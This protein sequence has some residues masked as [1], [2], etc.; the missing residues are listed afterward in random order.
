MTTT[1]LFALESDSDILREYKSG[2]TERAVTFF[3]R[4]Y[5][6]FVYSIALRY[7]KNNED[8]QDIAQDVFVKA[9]SSLTNFRGEASLKT[10]LYR[11]TVNACKNEIRKKKLL[12]FFDFAR[13][14]EE[15]D[16]ISPEPGPDQIHVDSE[17]YCNVHKA[18]AHLPEKQRETF[19]L[20]YFDELTYEEISN[21]LGTSVGG[22]KANYFQAV[23]KLMVILPQYGIGG[24]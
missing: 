24:M 23:Q 21:I 4:K 15:F 11:I 7:T 22:L 9:I 17:F 13:E 10:W 6:R 8:A 20:R 5:Q 2:D 18:L 16:I 1:V 12:R 3:V 14:D 19:A